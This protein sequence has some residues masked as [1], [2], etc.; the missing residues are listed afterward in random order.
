[1]AIIHTDGESGHLN[2]GQLNLKAH[3]CKQHLTTK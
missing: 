1:M 3:N 2:I